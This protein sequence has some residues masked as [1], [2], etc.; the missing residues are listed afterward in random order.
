[1]NEQ[2]LVARLEELTAQMAR[3]QQELSTLKQ[4]SQSLTP[5][6][7][8]AISFT[9]TRRQTLKRLGLALLGGTVAATMVGVPAAQAKIV[10]NPT[11]TGS[12]SKVGALVLPP[13]AA[14]P[15]G[16]AP[17][18]SYY[19]LVA[20]GSTTALD[21]ASLPPQNIGVYGSGSDTGVFGSGTGYAGVQGFGAY[22]GVYGSGNNTGIS[23]YGIKYGVSGK[24]GRIGGL[25]NS[26]TGS[27]YDTMPGTASV[28]VLANAGKSL[29]LSTFGANASTGIYATADGATTNFAGWFSGDV[30][31][32]DNLRVNKSLTV[33]GAK[34]FKIDHPLDPAN[35]YL[36][37]IAIES[38]DMK[39]V[40]D[41]VASLDEQGEATVELPAW[42]EALNSDYRYQ[43][44]SLDIAAPGLHISQ[45][46]KNGCFTISGG[47]PGQQVSWQVTG[48]RQDAYARAH[49]T[50][51]E[52]DKPAHEKDRYLD[53]A[54]FGQPMEKSI[55][56]Y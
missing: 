8:P 20:S 35:K 30:I 21:L 22:Y 11:L 50:P 27:T 26:D 37:H 5:P 52:E 13:G 19:G 31:I 23:G 51:V 12:T 28:G 2:V 43:L 48:I 15:T 1:M 56:P 7:Q 9:P 46:I 14:A 55:Y 25:F 32:T 44:T 38:P 3:L 34:A 33:L 49:R 16:T 24:G 6:Q 10:V 42:F 36:Y 18:G 47:Q 45:R 39:N 54:V 4:H 40:Y 17:N 53:P 41:G 29:D